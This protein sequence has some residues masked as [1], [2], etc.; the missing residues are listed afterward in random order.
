M[1]AVGYRQLWPYCAG[2]VGLVE[3][4]AAAIA[5]SAQLAKRQMTWL[6]RDHDVTLLG[7][8]S[9]GVL[10]ALTAKICAAACA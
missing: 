6:R 1:R 4:S 5:A 3:A 8:T 2:Q 10:E 7:D 9:V